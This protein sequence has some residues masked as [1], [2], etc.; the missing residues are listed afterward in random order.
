MWINDFNMEIKTTKLSKENKEYIYDLR[1]K[2]NFFKK[3]QKAQPQ[4]KEL[5]NLN[6]LKL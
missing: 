3:K 4:R 1:V 5:T 6:T 2:K